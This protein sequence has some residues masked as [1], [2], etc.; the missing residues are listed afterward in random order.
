LGHFVPL[1]GKK[2]IFHIFLILIL[3]LC[4]LVVVYIKKQA[5]DIHHSVAEVLGYPHTENDKAHA[6]T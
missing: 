2:F 1:I 3:L 5:W 4:P 6:M